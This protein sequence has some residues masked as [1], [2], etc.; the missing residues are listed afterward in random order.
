MTMKQ[1]YKIELEE[2]TYTTYIVDMLAETEEEA[3][4]LAKKHLEKCFDNGTY[5]YYETKAEEH[6]TIV[7][8]YNVTNTDDPFNPE[9]E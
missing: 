2:V 5:H 4:E 8:A 6:L 9:N 3:R 7:D 1:K